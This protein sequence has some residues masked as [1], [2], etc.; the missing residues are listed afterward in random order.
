[1]NV[2]TVSFVLVSLIE[3]LPLNEKPEVLDD[4]VELEDT[5][6]SIGWWRRRPP[7][8]Q[9]YVIGS[10]LNNTD[11]LAAHLNLKLYSSIFPDG[12]DLSTTSDEDLEAF[13]HENGNLHENAQTIIWSHGWNDND[14]TCKNLVVPKYLELEQATNNKY[15]VV[16]VD[17]SFWAKNVAA[18]L[19]SVYDTQAKQCIDV[20]SYLGKFL[21]K[22]AEYA[23]INGEKLHAIGH[24]LGAHIVGTMSRT[25]TQL[26]G[27][28]P[29]RVTGLDPAG[30]I[31]VQNKHGL[32]T[33][34]IKHTDGEFVDIIHTCGALNP[35]AFTMFRASRLGDL[36]QLGHADF[37]PN[38]GARQP[39]C[40]SVTGALGSAGCAH[41][42][43]NKYYIE[44]VSTDDDA[45]ATVICNTNGTPFPACEKHDYLGDAPKSQYDGVHMGF[46]ATR[47]T[48]R[49]L[50]YLDIDPSP[51]FSHCCSGQ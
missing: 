39:G 2:L 49:T 18:N 37:Y 46:H 30:P 41:G 36:H 17:W 11:H 47:P 51:P 14:N 33:H 42:R 26:S 6:S 25:W 50:Y 31:F 40:G 38:G 19:F 43:A 22:F 45:F 44:S 27:D 10:M 34:M 48:S 9:D 3:S 1:M 13:L 5:N 23:N 24:S 29:S 28:K 15:Q 16:C 8:Q 20:G 35:H 7:P 21:K 4:L 32:E 12:T